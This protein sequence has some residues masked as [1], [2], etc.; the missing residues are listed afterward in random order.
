MLNTTTK[1]ERNLLLGKENEF[2]Y[3]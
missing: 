1:G 2:G 3:T